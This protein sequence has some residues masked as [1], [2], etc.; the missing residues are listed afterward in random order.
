MREV[1]RV[2]RRILFV[3][4]AAGMGGAEHSLLGLLEQLDRDRY[5]PILAAVDGPLADRAEALEVE[6]H[7]LALP[8]LRSSPL[9]ALH[10]L[11]G[12]LALSALARRRQ[13]ALIHA[14]VLRATLYAAAAARWAGRPLVWHVR[15]IL[16]PS[17]TTRWLCR[18]AAAIIAISEAVRRSLPCPE[19]ARVIFNPVADPTG[20]RSAGDASRPSRPADVQRAALDTEGGDAGAL[21]ARRA[22][23]GLPPGRL[24]ASVG[25]L[26]AWKGH[27]RFLA[28]AERVADAHPDVH[29]LIIGGRV[30]GQDR[31]DLDYAGRLRRMTEAGPL[32]GRAHLLGQREDLASL[33]PEL[34]LLV[35][36]AEAEPFGR[37]VAEAQ[38]AGLPVLGFDEGGLPEIVVSGQ[39]GS[40][41]PAGDLDALAAQ[42]DALLADPERMRRMGRAGRLMASR[43]DPAVHARAVEA[44]YDSLLSGA[45][46]APARAFRAAPRRRGARRA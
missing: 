2:A 40:L 13:A 7:R 24:V 20:A 17:A 39:S 5:R 34:S 45:A 14:N 12:S 3:D 16:P 29:F 23:L 21:A 42:L 41:V 10:L 22:V 4:H 31:A 37:V 33:W 27:H 8:R 32:A 1:D 36:A 25:R 26:R 43:F 19:R 15:D 18:E 46:G 30:M 28:A 9:A 35:H 11:R 44:V 38:A 6:V